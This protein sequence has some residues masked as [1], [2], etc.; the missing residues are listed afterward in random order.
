VTIGAPGTETSIEVTLTSDGQTYDESLSFDAGDVALMLEPQAT[1]P[2]LYPG[3]PLIP[4]A[5]NV[6]AVAVADFYSASGVPLNPATLSYTWTL[7]DTTLD[8]SGIGKTSVLVPIPLQYRDS[9]VSLVVKTVDGSEV[10]GATETIAGNQPTVRVYQNDPLLG[11]LFD[12]AIPDA[13]AISGSEVSF[14]GAPF[15]FST[16]NGSPTL[17]WTLGGSP[18]QTGSSLTLRPQGSGAGTAALSLSANNQSTLESAV[19]NVSLSYGSSQ[20]TGLFGL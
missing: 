15:S 16:E 1:A 12:H 9:V 5:G 3:E 10:A 18:A 17:S 20:S 14:F 13:F 4:N 2:V 11:I 8:S 7:D 6:R 19:A